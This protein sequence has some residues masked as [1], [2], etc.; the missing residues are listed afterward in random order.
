VV[1]APGIAIAVVSLAFNLT[2]DALRDVLDP[3]GD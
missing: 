2:G 1:A 3:R